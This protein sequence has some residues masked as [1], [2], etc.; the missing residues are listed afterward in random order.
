MPK[1]KEQKLIG[2]D[3]GFFYH[4][5][6]GDKTTLRVFQECDVVVSILTIFE[7]HRQVLKTDILEWDGIIVL[8]EKSTIVMDVTRETV[9]R[10]ANIAHGTGMPAIDSLILSTF[11]IA[12]CTRIFTTDAHFELY[13]RKG[14]EIINLKKN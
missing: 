9:K 5:K 1:E 4:I 11:L 6:E 13:Q 12:G 14:I 10:A 7:L 3:T 8:L 2:A